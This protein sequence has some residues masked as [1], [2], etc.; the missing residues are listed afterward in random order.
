MPGTKSEPLDRQWIKVQVTYDTC[1][2]CK[3]P[4]ND[5]Y[6]A[7]KGCYMLECE[8]CFTVVAHQCQG[9]PDWERKT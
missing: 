3:I 6:Y 9:K 5:I 2:I 4:L 8:D 7:C 1:V